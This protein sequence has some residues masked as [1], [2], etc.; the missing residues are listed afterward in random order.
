LKFCIEQTI[1]SNKEKIKKGGYD[2]TV[3]KPRLGL[4]GSPNEKM[5][6]E[7]MKADL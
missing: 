4:R 6:I 1:I 3:W 5:S 2:R 7:D